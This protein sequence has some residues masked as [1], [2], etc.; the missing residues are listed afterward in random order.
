MGKGDRRRGRRLEVGK[1]TGDEK[2]TGEEEGDRGRG[3][4]Q[5][6][7]KGTGELEGDRR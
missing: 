7:G 6:V 3:R 4:G 1:R 5:E 2:R